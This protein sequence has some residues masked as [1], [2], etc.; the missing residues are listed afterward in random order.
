[1]IAKCFQ[2]ASK[3]SAPSALSSSSSTLDSINI[4]PLSYVPGA[5]IEKYLGNLNFFFIRETSSLREVLLHFIELFF[6]LDWPCT[7]F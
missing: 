1:M 6:P 4:T 7:V 5:R 2:N 3:P